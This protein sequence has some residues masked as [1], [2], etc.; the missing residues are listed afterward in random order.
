MCLS[1]FSLS[2]KPS[3]TTPVYKD[4]TRLEPPAGA[5]STAPE[6]ITTKETHPLIQ[7]SQLAQ[8]NTRPS[9]SIAAK[10]I[11]VLVNNLTAKENL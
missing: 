10:E 11:K 2:S 9:S 1:K 5:L 6:T 7:Q 4:Q 8:T 3:P